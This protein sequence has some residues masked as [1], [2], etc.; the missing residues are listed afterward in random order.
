MSFGPVFA[1]L[2]LLTVLLVGVAV[3]GAFRLAA[4]LRARGPRTVDGRSESVF[5]AAALQE[6]VSELRS[7]EQAQQARAE[8]SEGLNDTIVR[9]LAAGLLVVEPDG[10]VCSINPAACRLLGLATSDVGRPF[11]DV[12]RPLDPLPGLVAESLR[13]GHPVVRRS[14]DLRGLGRPGA[15]GAVLGV[16]VSP[17]FTH[18]GRF[19]GVICL[20]TDLTLVFE[21]EE[22]LRLREGLAAVGELTAG[23]A[24][25]FRNG[26]ATIDGY[27]RL[28]DLDRVD[29][30]T[31][32]LVEGIRAETTALGE[33]V[34]RFLEFARPEQVT[35]TRVDVR[36]LVAR[37][38]VEVELELSRT[39]GRLAVDGTFGAIDGDEVLLRQ[40][41][42]NVLRNAIEACTEDHRVPDVS[43]TGSLD[44]QTGGQTLVV[45]DNGPGFSP[46]AS[47]R[48]FEPFFTTRRGGTGLGLALVRK[49]AVLHNGRASVRTD[50][51]SAGGAVEIWLP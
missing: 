30:R 22:R 48:A 24:H 42:A 49:I 50:L 28:I 19:Q 20:L 27:S 13:T 37:A 38:A 16:S 5:V 47:R 32:P 29:D 44:P 17:R 6:A 25:E 26:L 36:Q 45:R 15:T 2:T 39:G 46:E 31:R 10:R 43:V 3:F 7:K 40:A 14:I 51:G 4:A 9:D 21:L 33:V 23:I 35:P 18:D 41:L 8:A 34:T 1:L 11:D 12:L